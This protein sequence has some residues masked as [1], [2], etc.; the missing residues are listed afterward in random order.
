MAA[1]K[2]VQ[3]PSHL[4]AHQCGA[5]ERLLIYSG[6]WTKSYRNLLLGELIYSAALIN[7]VLLLV[8][9]KLISVDYYPLFD[10]TGGGGNTLQELLACAVRLVGAVTWR[11]GWM[12]G[13]AKKK[14]SLHSKRFVRPVNNSGLSRRP[15][16]AEAEIHLKI[17]AG[18][19]NEWGREGGNLTK[20]LLKN[21]Y[22]R[23]RKSP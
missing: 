4:E 3:P 6:A 16:S 9:N 15:W 5:P 7:S 22:K 10:C 14:R 20:N 1:Y 2:R 23:G 21:P 12:G 18:G 13:G 11:L 17:A 8:R 19:E